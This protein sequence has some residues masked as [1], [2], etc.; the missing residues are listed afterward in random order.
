[1]GSALV[2]R[3]MKD[4][5]EAE[6]RRAV[7]QRRDEDAYEDGHRYS[8][9]WGST[10]GLHICDRTFPSIE[11]AEDYVEETSDKHEPLLAVKARRVPKATKPSASLV[12]LETK[13]RA[14]ENAIF[15]FPQTIIKR[16]RA[17]KSKTRGC[18]T[19]GSSIAV[20]HIRSPSCPVCSENFLYS[21]TD[22]TRL[23]T[24]TQKKDALQAQ[25]KEARV[26]EIATLERR[27]VSTVVW[28]VGGW[29]P[30]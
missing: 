2:I 9:T 22:E 18:S 4:M 30:S 5:P 13:A 3:V 17:G 8:G 23:K 27:G 21:T 1:M 20:T 7:E 6:L 19:C 29:C 25:L 15:S 10:H 16:V 14:A 28:V 11:E 26:R 24:L 12:A